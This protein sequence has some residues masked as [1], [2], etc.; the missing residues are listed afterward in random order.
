MPISNLLAKN[1]QNT[2]SHFKNLVYHKNLFNFLRDYLYKIF[3]AKKQVF[4]G[5]I[6]TKTG[7]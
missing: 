7:Q 3:T 1:L 5:I 6:L 2:R 4:T